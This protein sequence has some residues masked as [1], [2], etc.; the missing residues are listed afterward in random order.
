MAFD[1]AESPKL[2]QLRARLLELGCQIKDLSGEF[3]TLEGSSRILYARNPAN[4]RFAILPIVEQ[5]ARISPWHI[6]NI[7]RRLNVITGF[8]TL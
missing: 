2:D 6:G 7:E 3:V 8:P 4:G 5:D 1:F